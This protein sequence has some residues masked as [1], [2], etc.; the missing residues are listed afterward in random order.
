MV[1]E[2][3]NIETK[4]PQLKFLI[5]GW[6]VGLAVAGVMVHLTGVSI[7]AIIGLIFGYRVIRLIIRVIG[8][9]LSIIFTIVS[10]LVMIAT[11]LLI[12]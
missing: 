2:V 5:S 8:L 10:I 7:S 6:V 4:L 1:H 12:T 9:A 11:I 3:K